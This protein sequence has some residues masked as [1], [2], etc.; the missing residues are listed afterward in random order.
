MPVD[1]SSDRVVLKHPKGASVEILLYGATIVSWKA[2]GKDNYST[3][4]ERLFVSSK[5]ALDGSKAVRGGIPVV[6]PCFGPPEHPD[7][8]KLPQH[9]FA[10]N[11]IWSFDSVVMDNDAGVSIRLTL[12]PKPSITALYAKDFQLSYVVTLAEHQLST[13]FHVSNPSAAE[14]LEFQ[15]LLHTY[16]RAPAKDVSISPLLGKHY[17][18]KTEK[19]LEARNTLKEERRESVDVR[20]FTDSVYEKAPSTVNVAWPG[21]GLELKLVHFTT[22][23]LWNPQAEAGSKMGDMEENGWERF[24][25]V[26]PGYVRGFKKLGPGETW[27]GQQVLSVV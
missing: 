27:V 12:L 15:A 10:R 18:D 11:E 8:F 23:T 3:P 16:I 1:Q 6:F 17:V 20:A 26:E 14:A 7:H 24:V 9:G 21:G 25:C 13:D 5:A 22:L 2:P 4:A 19:S